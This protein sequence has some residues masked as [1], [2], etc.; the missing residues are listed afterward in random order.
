MNLNAG[1]IGWLV[2]CVAGFALSLRSASVLRSRSVWTIAG[3]LATAAYFAIAAYDA[4]RAA[5]APL[6]AD[7]VALAVLVLAFVIA[8]IRDEPQAEPWYW[9]AHAGPTGRERRASK[10]K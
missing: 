8:G 6:H 5:H 10:L 9:P 7:Y 4:A 2:I 3:W 1:L